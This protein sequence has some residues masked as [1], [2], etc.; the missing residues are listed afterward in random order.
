MTAAVKNNLLIGAAAA[1][2]LYCIHR[3]KSGVSGIGA[4]DWHH[5]KWILERE[6]D[7]D[8][9]KGYH[10]Q[11]YGALMALERVGKKMGYRNNTDVSYGRAFFYAIQRKT[12]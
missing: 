8:F 2:V 11:N 1:G 5:A 7:L 12:R 9:T 4:V 3:K 10:E 6:Y